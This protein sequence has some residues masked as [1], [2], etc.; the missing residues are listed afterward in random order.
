[1]RA[2]RQQRAVVALLKPSLGERFPSA[3][4]L[5]CSG[6]DHLT[7]ER[8]LG[9][10]VHAES[11]VIVGQ[12]THHFRIGS[13]YA[14]C[15]ENCPLPP[16]GSW[17]GWVS[18]R[19]SVAPNPLVPGDLNSVKPDPNMGQVHVNINDAANKMRIN[20][21]IIR[22]CPHVIILRQPDRVDQGD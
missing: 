5:W 6:C 13:N 19:A 15:L 7:I 11:S 12:V 17:V 10:K 22:P 21:V 20:R 4:R 3:Y 9:V 14:W 1:V 16:G 8:C 2:A 18:D